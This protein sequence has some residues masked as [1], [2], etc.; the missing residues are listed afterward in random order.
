MVRA[1]LKCHKDEYDT[2]MN[3][4]EKAKG[5]TEQKR[6]YYSNYGFSNYKDVVLGKT[7]KLIKDKENYDK[8]HLEN[9]L[10][11]WKKKAVNRYETLT[12]EGRLRTEIEVWTGDKELDIIR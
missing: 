2:F 8:F 1:S 10:E 11:W 9:I 4:I 5:L 6:Y 7:D 3:T 12:N